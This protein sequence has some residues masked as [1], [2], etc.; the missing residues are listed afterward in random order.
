MQFTF[1]DLQDSIGM[2]EETTID[3]LK[4]FTVDWEEEFGLESLT[5][6]DFAKL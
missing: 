3:E 6:K 5:G 1:L 2:P 4:W